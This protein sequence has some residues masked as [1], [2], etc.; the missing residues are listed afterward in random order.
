MKV[1][2][3]STMA[4]PPL[5]GLAPPLFGLMIRSS[6]TFGIENVA[7]KLGILSAVLR[8]RANM[9]VNVRIETRMTINSRLGNNRRSSGLSDL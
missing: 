8:K 2:N 1:V 3:N 7:R 4:D 6:F 5:N 9:A